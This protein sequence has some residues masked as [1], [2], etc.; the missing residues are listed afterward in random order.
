MNISKMDFQALFVKLEV[1][2]KS[3]FFEMSSP[4]GPHPRFFNP[5]NMGPV[6]QMAANYISN[7]DLN[8]IDEYVYFRQLKCIE[9]KLLK[10][11]LM[12]L[13]QKWKATFLFYKIYGTV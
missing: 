8:H 4:E 13:E 1:C 9:M 7:I 6:G 3:H 10:Q 11:V 12:Q 2:F 5:Q